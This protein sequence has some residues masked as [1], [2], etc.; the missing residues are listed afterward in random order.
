LTL[1]IGTLTGRFSLQVHNAD[2]VGDVKRRIQEC[3]GIP[4]QSQILLWG[5]KALADDASPIAAFGIQDGSSLR[6]VLHMSSGM[7]ICR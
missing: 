4:M 7:V 6:L 5:D 1:N 3:E 2:D